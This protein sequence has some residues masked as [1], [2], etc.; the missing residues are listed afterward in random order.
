M[1][2]VGDLGK[3][4]SPPHHVMLSFC[5]FCTWDFRA[6]LVRLGDGSPLPIDPPSYSFS[7]SKEHR[8]ALQKASILIVVE[9][10]LWEPVRHLQKGVSARV[11]PKTGCVR[12]RVQ[13][14]GASGSC[15]PCALECPKSAHFPGCQKGVPDTPGALKPISDPLLT[16]SVNGQINHALVFVLLSRQFLRFRAAFN[17]KIVFPKGPKIEKIQDRPP[18]LKFSI[19]IEIFKRAACQTPIFVGN[20]EGPG[21][22]ISIEND[23][24]NR[25]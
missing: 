22:K 16:Y 12:G 13:P 2:D 8:T 10:K 4:K 23:F 7:K 25:E 9:P 18:G 19:E 17:Q 6:P 20:S 5:C 24:F 21:L 14:G 11:S 1:S 3:N 15:G